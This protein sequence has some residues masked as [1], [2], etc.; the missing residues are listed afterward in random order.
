MAASTR[1]PILE[2]AD[3]AAWSERLADHHD[4]VPVVSLKLAKA[5][6]PR[7]TVTQVEAVEAAVCFG[8]ID[9][10]VARFDAHFY[11]QRFTPR[12]P[13]SKWSEV[14]RERALRLIAE[15]RMRPAGRREF[16]AAQADGRLDAAYA[17]QSSI[18]VPEDLAAALADRPEAREF[19]DT[20]TSAQR[21]RFLYRLHHV[22]NPAR[23]ATRIRDY[24]E[25]L[26]ARR[27]L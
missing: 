7:P 4:G 21:Y 2:F 18:T 25:V 20:L 19:F 10:Q 15:G 9:G 8:W 11:L 5:G 14:N 22:A 3:A 23:R 26:S 17:P 16:E 1:D 6:S 13:R 24:V 27:T 12:R